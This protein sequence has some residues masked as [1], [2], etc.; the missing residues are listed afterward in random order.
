[1]CLAEAAIFSGIGAALDLRDDAVEL[2]GEVGGRALVACAPDDAPEI[3]SLAAESGVPL[4]RVGEVG[5][6]TLLG[7]ELQRLVS[8]WEGGD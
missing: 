4:R 1:M 6:S 8:A 2:F 7:V 5:G 3:E